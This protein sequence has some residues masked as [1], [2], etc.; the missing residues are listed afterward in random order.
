MGERRRRYRPSFRSH[1]TGKE[2]VVASLPFG[3]NRWI[4]A[5]NIEVAGGYV[6]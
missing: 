3:E 5:Q 6:I 1:P 4:N 2:S